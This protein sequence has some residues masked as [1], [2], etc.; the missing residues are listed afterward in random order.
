MTDDIRFERLARD[1]LELGPV[2]AP[3]HVIQAAFLE[4]D[5]TSQERDLRVPWRF[6]AMP[7][8]ALLAA[9]AATIVVLGLAG[10][11]IVGAPRSGPTVPPVS[12]PTIALTR[13]SPSPI[14]APSA[15]P[16]ATP[17][18]TM[19]PLDGTFT[20]PWYGYRVH[21][22]SI[23]QVT[24]G[25]G[26]WPV[27]LNLPHGDA[28][29]DQLMQNGPNSA[30]F[31]G[32]SVKLPPGMT[33]DGFRAFASPAG[34]TCEAVDALPSQVSVDGVEA[35]VSLNG[36]LSASELHGLIWD[37]VLVSGGRGYDFT[38]DGHLTAAE[39]L[40]LLDGVTLQP[41]SARPPSG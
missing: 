15:T 35:L 25:K 27:G 14:P 34:Q 37:V 31:V 4:I 38:I 10:A 40:Q 12:S 20:S 32:A 5:T 2:E 9:A 17:R 30:R 33:L 28:R 1:W 3:D 8:F 13:P 22:P 6:P 21:Y 29:L 41:A 19:P 39:A 26:P 18:A 36:C 16:S 11:L 23:W 7:R 24:P